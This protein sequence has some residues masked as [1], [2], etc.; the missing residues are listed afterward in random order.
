[1]ATKNGLRVVRGNGFGIKINVRALRPD[2]TEILDFDLGAATEVVALITQNSV[3]S[4]TPFE[5]DGNSMIITF[6]GHQPV[7]YYGL[8]VSGM[9]EGERWRFCT[10]VLFEIVANNNQA[11]IPEGCIIYDDNYI[12]GA[13]ITLYTMGPQADWDE[14][15]PTKQS[16]IKNKPDL[17][18][19]ATNEALQSERQARI[20]DVYAEETRAKAVERTI[21]NYIAEI[22]GKIPAA[23]TPQNQLAD[24]KYVDDGLTTKQDAIDDLQN[25]RSG[26]TAGSTAVQ[27]EALNEYLPKSGGKM[28]GDID[29]NDQAVLVRATGGNKRNGIK[30]I[31]RAQFGNDASKEGVYVGN[32]NMHTFIETFTQDKAV[33]RKTGNNW[34][35]ILDEGNSK[36]INGSSLF[37]ESGGNIEVYQKPA[38]G[39]PASDIAD[40]VIPDVSNYGVLSQTQTWS[41]TTDTGY[42]YAMSNIVRGDI[43]KTEIDKYTLLG[44]TFNSTTGYFELNGI[45]DLSLEE[46]RLAYHITYELNGQWTGFVSALPLRTTFP[47]VNGMTVNGGAI[48]LKRNITSHFYY[49]APKGTEVLRVAQDNTKQITLSSAS[50]Y[51]FYVY[52]SQLR[53]VI[54]CI[55]VYNC[56]NSV[57]NSTYFFRNCPMLETIRLVDLRTSWNAET[58]RRLSVASVAYAVEHAAN[59]TTAITITLHELVYNNCQADTTE[60]EY[61]STTYT[62]IIALA[63]AKNITIAQAS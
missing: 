8:D 29:L 3:Q 48:N 52:T 13:N 42:T 11:N 61:N 33:K 30:Y 49:F 43:A 23:A 41:G 55:S 59:G 16:Y 57:T 28:S 22:N 62:G 5:R 47:L 38:G 26:A 63:T 14:T 19:Y 24:K 9:Y 12:I 4:P 10:P 54:G 46:I 53:E 45:T 36:T 40:G 25:I 50:N 34:Y 1:M 51:I 6:D 31:P 21:A 17:T 2:G 37:S 58:L 32:A 15:D 18:V 20:D 44:A 7:G 60:Y 56:G 35:S 27:P 39:I